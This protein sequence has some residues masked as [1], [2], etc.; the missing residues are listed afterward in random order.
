M[1]STHDNGSCI[2]NDWLGHRLARAIGD[3]ALPVRHLPSGAGHD[4]MAMADLCPVGMLF[5]RCE[6]GISHHPA[7]NMSVEDA[8]TAARV[9][10]R[11]LSELDPR[12][13]EEATP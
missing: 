8:D 13:S 12:V 6:G 10:L 5:V 7:E 4:A 2:C 3:S 9:L 1:Q 11:F